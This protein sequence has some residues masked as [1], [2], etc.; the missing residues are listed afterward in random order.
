MRKSRSLF[1]TL[2]LMLLF[3]TLVHG[4]WQTQD[5]GVTV[6]LRDVCFVDC[7][8]GWAVGDSAT[9]IATRDGGETWIPQ[10]TRI[11]AITLR[12]VIFIDKDIGYV[13]GDN[14]NIPSPEGIILLTKDGGLTWE[15]SKAEINFLLKDLSFVHADTGWVV[16]AAEDP[17]R[18]G[19]LLH[20]QDGG[21]TWQTQL[22]TGK[23]QLLVAVDFI[24]ERDGWMIG[25]DFFD[26]FSFTDIYKTNDG[27]IQW[28]IM[29]EIEAHV[30]E[31]S[32][33][34]PDT[35]WTGDLGFF[36]NSNDGGISWAVKRFGA[37]FISGIWD[38]GQLDG[39]TGWLV[40][41]YLANT[42]LSK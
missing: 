18:N 36:A 37:R 11:R 32:I 3:T 2:F 35:I 24:N 21:E 30:S 41:S 6:N 13:I 28:R 33:I 31:M 8:H 39:Q 20:T 29:N 38:I 17:R 12:K 19:I 9:I 26:N 16:G 1:E 10:E 25:G 14:N 23:N 22:E 42:F 15:V 40:G 7:L 34:S 5:S 4:Q 27:G